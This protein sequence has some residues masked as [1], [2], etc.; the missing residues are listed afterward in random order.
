[1]LLRTCPDLL[2]SLLTVARV[3]AEMDFADT[4]AVE[5]CICAVRNLCY[6]LTEIA[7][8]AVDARRQIG[9]L[10]STDRLRGRSRSK[11]VMGKGKLS[12]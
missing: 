12:W 3:A 6:S 11:S 2:S 4:K 10:L 8:P 7:Q 5:N 1:M 9:R